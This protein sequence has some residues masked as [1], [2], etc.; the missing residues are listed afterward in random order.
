MTRRYYTYAYL[1]ENGTP[2]YIGRGC[3]RRAYQRHGKFVKVPDKSRILFLKKELSYSDSVKHEIYMIS[4][5]GRKS[6]GGVLINRTTGGE[7]TRGFSHPQTPETR[8]IISQKLSIAWSEGRH[9]DVSGSNNPNKEGLPGDK[10]GRSKL[11][12][13]DRRQIAFEYIPGKK[14]GHNGNCA[15]LAER[16][17]VG[18]SQIRRIAGDPRWIS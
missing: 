9:H 6:D 1:R 7:G 4:V 2:Y 10:N 13:D 5:Y 3:G 17:K 14:A 18:M 11:T 8:L 12:N 15:D 16:Y